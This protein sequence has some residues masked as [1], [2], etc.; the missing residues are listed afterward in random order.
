MP[1]V[2]YMGFRLYISF[3]RS[4]MAVDISY[5]GKHK[6]IANVVWSCE[7]GNVCLPPAPADDSSSQY[8]HISLF[9]AAIG[10]V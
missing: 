8:T 4:N 6:S 3:I 10:L 9:K 7:C 5:S 1:N 2:V